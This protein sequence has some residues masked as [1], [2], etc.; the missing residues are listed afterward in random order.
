MRTAATQPTSYPSLTCATNPNPNPTPTLT[1]TPTPT[2]TLSS[3][4]TLTSAL[5]PHYDERSCDAEGVQAA[6]AAL[7]E[8]LPAYHDFHVAAPDA[9]WARSVRAPK[10]DP[11]PNPNPNPNSPA[12]NPNP[13]PQTRSVRALCEEVASDATVAGPAR[14]VVVVGA[15]HLPGLQALLSG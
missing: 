8:L 7:R 5:A 15:R 4:L 11:N 14:V 6:N 1:L 10:P 12:P 3:T 9:R 2:L 13:N